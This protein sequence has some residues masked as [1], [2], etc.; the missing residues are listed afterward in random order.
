MSN[1]SKPWRYTDEF[2]SLKDVDGSIFYMLSDKVEGAR[3]E[4][5]PLCNSGGMIEDRIK[6]AFD[7][8]GR[9]EMLQ[10]VVDHRNSQFGDM[11]DRMVKAETGAGIT[12][13]SVVLES[14]VASRELNA[15]A[16][17][18]IESSIESYLNNTDLVN[19]LKAQ[20]E[21]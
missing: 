10:H 1:V 20:S 15:E 17:D 18:V 19:R 16:A 14:L 6:E 2:F 12:A 11:Y 4:W 7:S 21:K 9:A 8:L 13:M 3:D 5:R